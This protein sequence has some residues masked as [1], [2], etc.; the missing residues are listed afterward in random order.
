MIK[1][2]DFLKFSV[3]SIALIACVNTD[4]SQTNTKTNISVSKK[5]D[6]GKIAIKDSIFI[7]IPIINQG[8]SVLKIDSVV[9]SCGCTITKLQKKEAAVKDSIIIDL[10]YVDNSHSSGF[11]DKSI[12]IVANTNEEFHVVHILGE[13][14]NNK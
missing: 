1:D 3:L 13:I 8:P 7:K 14:I 9:A 11:I 4:S 6:V 5:I 2:I 12:V 10:K